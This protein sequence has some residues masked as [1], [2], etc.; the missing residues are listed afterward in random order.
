MIVIDE[1]QSFNKVTRVTIVT[2]EGIAFERY[3]LYEHG[4]EMHLQDDGRTL[5]IFPRI[6]GE[7]PGSYLVSDK[8]KENYPEI[9]DD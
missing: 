8:I 3:N 9:F 1:Q 5:K 2:D 6:Q 4:V 7:S